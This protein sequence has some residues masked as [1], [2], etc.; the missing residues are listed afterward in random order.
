MPPSE[1]AFDSSATPAVGALPA[2]AALD[3]AVLLLLVAAAGFAST[4]LGQDANWDLQTYHYYNP[5]AWWH[6]S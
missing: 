4:F 1:R 6:G 2:A 5:L 3:A